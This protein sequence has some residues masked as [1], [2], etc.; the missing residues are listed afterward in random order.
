MLTDLGQLTDDQMP[1]GTKPGSQFTTQIATDDLA[2][3]TVSGLKDYGALFWCTPQGPVF[4]KNPRVQNKATAMA[5]LQKYVEGGGAWAGVHSATDF[6]KTGEFPWYTNSLVGAYL[7]DNSWDADG[8]S[9]TLKVE[10]A[11]ADHPVMR[12]VP[13]T[14]S[15]K[16]EWFRLNRDVGAQPGFQILARLTAC[17]TPNGSCSADNRPAVWIKDFGTNSGRMF[18]TIRGH[19]PGVYYEPEFRLLVLQGILWATHRLEK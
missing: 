5:A 19:A 4:S 18:Y 12:D 1:P 3:F 15:V 10:A 14:W 6:E 17:S 16:D 13:P 2:D 7:P 8:S 11:Y 9:G